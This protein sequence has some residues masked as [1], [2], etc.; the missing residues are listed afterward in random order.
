MIRIRLMS[1]QW[2]STQRSG[3]RNTAVLPSFASQH[4][5]H[6]RSSAQH[7]TAQHSRIHSFRLSLAPAT[8]A[9]IA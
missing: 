1:D 3:S 2:H 5:N 7:N 6:Y 8:M 9:V 4:S